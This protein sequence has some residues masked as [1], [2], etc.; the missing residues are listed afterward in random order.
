MK[1]CMD[2][3]SDSQASDESGEGN[4]AQVE[5]KHNQ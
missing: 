1:P 4:M 5:V 3:V 2:A